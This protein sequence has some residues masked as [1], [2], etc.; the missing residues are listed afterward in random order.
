MLAGLA[1]YAALA[2]IGIAGLP[3]TRLLLPGLKTRGYAFARIIGLLLTG[4]LFWLFVS[5]KILPNDLI[6]ILTALLIVAV[7]G[8]S[9]TRS[10]PLREIKRLWAED[11]RHLV[12]VELFILIAFFAMALFRAANPDIRGTEK[13]M[14]LAFINSILHSPAFPPEDPW[15][16]GYSISYYYFGYVL[17]AL[18]IRLSGVSAGIGFNLMAATVFSLAGVGLYALALCVLEKIQPAGRDKDN[19][20][21]GHWLALLAP[22]FT[23]VVSN[24]EGL[25]EFLHVRGWFWKVGAD[26]SLVSRF[27][28]WLD[29]QELINAPAQPFQSWPVR[30]TGL[31]WWR[32]SRV[33]SDYNLA[34][35]RLEIIDEFPFFSFLLADL[36]PHV[37]ILPFATL[38]LAIILNVLLMSPDSG[39][40]IAGLRLPGQ[41]IAWVTLVIVLGSVAFLNTWDLPAYLTLYLAAVFVSCWL[42]QGWKLAL[43]EILSVGLLL[44]PAILLLYLPFFVSFSSQAGGILPSMIFITRGAHY[45]VM[46]G[47]LLI[48]IGGYFLVELLRKPQLQKTARKV[49]LPAVLGL[50]GLTALNFG[51][52]AALAKS[53][54]WVTALPG[55][56][57]YLFARLGAVFMNAQGAA[58]DAA[59]VLWITAWQRFVSHPGTWITLLLTLIAGAALL[60]T[61]KSSWKED[62]TSPDNPAMVFL[63]FLVLG[64]TA[65]TAFPEFFYLRDQ[66]G[67]RMNTIFKF[68][69]QAW[70]LWSLATGISAALLWRSVKGSAGLL[71]K[72]ALVL[73]I[74]CGLAYPIFAIPET[75]G[76][77]Q[78]YGLELDGAQFLRRSNPAEM[79]AIEW[80]SAAPRGV[81]LEAVGGSYSGYARV[82]TFSGQPTVLGWP[83]HESQWRGGYAE[84][85]NR[86]ADIETIY[87][88]DDWSAARALLDQ[89]HVR[90]I[91]ISD[92]E[93]STYRINENKFSDRLG[94]VFQQQGV[95]IY[96]Y[97]AGE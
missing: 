26:G 74:L 72:L 37:L 81:V 12:F 38:I 88:T 16:A 44:I 36:H 56:L 94:L 35:N 62:Q 93:R 95:T 42:R 80:L 23:L 87:T 15:L 20:Q 22:V 2:L 76:G 60:L 96:E 40:H 57:S 31:L 32:A 54:A 6:G 90:Y 43:S 49:I 52:G 71:M 28:S 41:P 66:F 9:F 65:L 18:L 79:A 10:N 77:E 78:V 85:G 48:P 55:S 51:F 33:L 50:T 21:D 34:G 83:G 29:I 30:P 97:N 68:Y 63:A 5:F 8:Y 73:T 64:G 39:F 27:W 1:W 3:L 13:P 53:S 86:Q 75:T 91:F 92:L 69:Y 19:K 25:L 24:F 58:P 84:M 59:N 61:A 4:Y 17:T 7:C 67:W 89:Y 45:W 82:S 46:F 47:P 11:R 14:E 70:I